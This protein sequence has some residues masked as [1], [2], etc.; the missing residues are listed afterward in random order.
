VT[1]VR[2]FDHAQPI[3]LLRARRR[4]LLVRHV[5]GFRQKGTSQVYL[6]GTFARLANSGY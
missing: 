1:L 6:K 4:C 3:A 2:G 5:P